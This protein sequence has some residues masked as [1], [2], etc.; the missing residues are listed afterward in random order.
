VA[1]WHYIFY[2]LHVLKK[3]YNNAVYVFWYRYFLKM[4]TEGGRNM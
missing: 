1:C 2:H 3:L 4:A